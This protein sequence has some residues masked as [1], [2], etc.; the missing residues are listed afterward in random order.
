MKKTSRACVTGALEAHVHGYRREL[1]R[2]GYSPWAALFHVHLMA[3][4][5]RWL[6]Q[7]G[8]EPAEFDQGRVPSS[9]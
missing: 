6:A 8:M 4:V 9:F 5:S 3:H 1:A 2:G 7:N